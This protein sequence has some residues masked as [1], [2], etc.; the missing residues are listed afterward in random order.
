MFLT[1][2]AELLSA[3]AVESVCLL[4]YID[5]KIVCSGVLSLDSV[6]V[7]LSKMLLEVD[8]GTTKGEERGGVTLI[9]GKGGGTVTEP[10]DEESDGEPGQDG[11]RGWKEVAGVSGS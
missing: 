9:E 4:R 7:L 3:E 2:V 11:E 8:A 6:L 1:L 5:F 10:E